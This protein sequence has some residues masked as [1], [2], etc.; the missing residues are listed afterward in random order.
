MNAISDTRSGAG[1]SGAR[2]IDSRVDRGRFSQRLTGPSAA[3]PSERRNATLAARTS[4]GVSTSRH[5]QPQGDRPQGPR[6]GQAGHGTGQRRAVAICPPVGKHDPDRSRRG[7]RRP[8]RPVRRRGRL[9]PGPAPPSGEQGPHRPLDQAQA[10][11]RSSALGATPG[12]C[13]QPLGLARGQRHPHP[14]LPRPRRIGLDHLRPTGEPATG[15]TLLHPRPNSGHK[16]P[17]RRAGRDRPAPQTYLTCGIPTI[18]HDSLNLRRTGRYWL[19]GSDTEESRVRTLSRPPHRAAGE[20]GLSACLFLPSPNAGS[21]GGNRAA[22]ARLQ[23][24]PNALVAW[25]GKTRTPPAS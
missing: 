20:A 10:P 18:L 2:T 5:Q 19:A 9:P 14:R 15:T 21:L 7:D 4:W 1:R 25:R 16:R 17:G 24:E 8:L 23:R 12:D 3:L 13:C 6:L 11:R 22:T